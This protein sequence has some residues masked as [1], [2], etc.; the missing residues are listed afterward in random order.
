MAGIE[1]LKGLVSG[2]F[3]VMKFGIRTFKDLPTLK[4]EIKDVDVGEGTALIVQIA[5]Q[6]VPEVLQELKR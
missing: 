2:V 5:T 1:K 4:E 3:G 6:E